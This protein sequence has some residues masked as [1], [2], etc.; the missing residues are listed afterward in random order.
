MKTALAALG[1]IVIVAAAGSQGSETVLYPLMKGEIAPEAQNLWDVGNRAMDDNGKPDR[2][3]V[4][5]ADWAKLTQAAQRMR[6]A[7]FEL[8]SANRIAVV[9][10]G[11]K[12]QDEGAP[13][14]SS[15]QDIERYIAADRKS[16]TDHAQRL[17]AISD[18]LIRA[19][20]ERDVVRLSD[21]TGRLDEVCEACH[22]QFW[23][24]PKPAQ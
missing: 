14:S 24:P 22:T 4:S 23:Y 6:S 1:A 12:L 19:G 9:G 3:R 7:A 5:A 16:F 8:A 10:A 2:S 11:A 18:E 20:K 15:P 17:V 21:A 13:G